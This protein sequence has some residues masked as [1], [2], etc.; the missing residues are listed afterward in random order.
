MST[1][2]RTELY[3]LSHSNHSDI[4]WKE[5]IWK[6]IAYEINRTGKSEPDISVRLKIGSDLSPKKSFKFSADLT[7]FIKFII[8][9]LMPNI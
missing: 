4:P 2:T 7:R 6:G 1:P 8:Q 3:D 5:N 9:Y